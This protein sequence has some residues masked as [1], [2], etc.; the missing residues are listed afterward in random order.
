MFCDLSATLPAQLQGPAGPPGPPGETE[1]PPEFLTKVR[2]RRSLREMQ[3]SA[4][5]DEPEPEVSSTR[6][7]RVVA[8]PPVQHKT[9]ADQA[10]VSTV[11]LRVFI[12]TILPQNLAST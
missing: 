1:I 2:K 7:E 9:L 6:V 8:P 11:K 5:Q 10:L 3:P 12:R 4:M